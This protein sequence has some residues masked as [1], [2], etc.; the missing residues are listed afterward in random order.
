MYVCFECW[1]AIMNSKRA[2]FFHVFFEIFL[3]CRET[4]DTFFE[5]RDE[6]FV[7]NVENSSSVEKFFKSVKTS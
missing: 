2:I 4:F 1:R 7:E 3:A 5:A 6:I